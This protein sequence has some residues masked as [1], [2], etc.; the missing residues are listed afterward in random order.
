MTDK[1][2]L[3]PTDWVQMNPEDLFSQEQ[4]ALEA[5]QLGAAQTRLIE[6]REKIPAL[7]RLAKQQNISDLENLNELAALLFT[8]EVY[9]GYPMALLEKGKFARLTRWLDKLTTHDLSGLDVSKVKTIDTWLELLDEAGMFIFHSTGTTGKLSF[10]PR[11]QT[12]KNAW[13]EGNWAFMESMIPGIRELKLPVFWPA[14]RDGR[15]AGMRLIGHFGP[16]LAGGEAEYHSLFDSPMSADLMSI[17]GRLRRAQEAGDLKALDTLKA[18]IQTKGEIVRLK[19]QRGKMTK[20]FF[21]KMMA[22]YKGQ[23][24]FLMASATDLLDIAQEGLASGVSQIFAPDSVFLTGGGFKGREEID[25]WQDILREFYGVDQI[26]MTYG[27]TELNSYNPGCK[28]GR[29]HVLPWNIVFVLDD[30]GKPLPRRGVQTGRAGYFDLLAETYW[31]GILTGD[32]VTVHFDD[33]CAC[34]W[35]GPYIEPNVMRMTEYLGGEDII[36]CAGVQAAHDEM[37]DFSKLSI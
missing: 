19:T 30:E 32:R 13:V 4:R 8:H 26:H 33:D 20:E 22:G 6:L 23:R 35:K 24:V 21:E 18:I 3:E 1:I 15:Q 28:A 16:L 37:L 17:A 12:E 34:G 25:G 14:F 27:M 31:G 5:I 7:S 10:F 9:K 29:Y 11:S 36:S 2:F